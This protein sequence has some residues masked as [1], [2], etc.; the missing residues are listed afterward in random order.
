MT[1]AT[2]SCTQWQ[3]TS[4]GAGVQRGAPVTF[5]PDPQYSCME[6]ANSRVQVLRLPGPRYCMLHHD[7]WVNHRDYHTRLNLA[8]FFS[9]TGAD[10]FVAGPPFS[11]RN[12]VSAYPQGI[13]HDGKLYVA[14][15]SGPG[16]G[17]RSIEGAVIDPAPSPDSFYLWP[18]QKGLVRMVEGEDE[19][20]ERRMI[21][22]NPTYAAAQPSVS[23]EGNRTVLRFERA[24]SAGVEIDPVDF[25]AGES[26]QLSFDLKVLKVQER[27]NLIL[28]SFGDRIPVR[29]GT[30]SN[31]Q[32]TLYANGADQWLA[33]GPVPV[34]QWQ[35]LTVTFG[36]ASFAVRIGDAAPQ[37]FPNP[38]SRTN[39]R[40]YLGDGYEVDYVP[41][42]WGSEFLIDMGSVRTQVIRTPRVTR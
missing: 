15:T 26:L 30:P 3:L 19:H 10:D 38:L 25:A 14:Y 12:V 28:C 13:E 36:P 11:R 42:N 39:P 22:Q 4:L 34:G 16:T 40:L 29:L 24:A 35:K 18:R 8:L 20:G 6:T 31:R 33:A 17:P 2:P 5:D 27:G 9:R 37:A 1:R 21:R 23:Q 41:S 32:G 7:V